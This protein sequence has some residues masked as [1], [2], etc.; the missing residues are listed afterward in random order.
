MPQTRNNRKCHKR[1]LEGKVKNSFLDSQNDQ[2]EIKGF[3]DSN[4]QTKWNCYKEVIQKWWF[5]KFTV[6]RFW[7]LTIEVFVNNTNLTF[8][9]Y[10]YKIST[11]VS[12]KNNVA[13]SRTRTRNTDHHWLDRHQTCKPVMVSVASSSPTGGNF[14]FLR[15]LNAY[16]VQKMTE[17]SDLCY[18]R[19]PRMTNFKE[20][21]DG[22]GAAANI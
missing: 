12:W 18:L 16:S 2:F 5:R 4:K 15:H 1:A 7:H 17:M 6:V 3:R 21:C 11:E 14:N 13:S 8:L 10:L 9:T 22:F 20:S 19:K